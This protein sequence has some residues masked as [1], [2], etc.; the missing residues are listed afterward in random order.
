MKT[1]NTIIQIM[2]GCFM[3]AIVLGLA[4]IMAFWVDD[5]ETYHLDAY[6]VVVWVLTLGTGS[7]VFVKLLMKIKGGD[8]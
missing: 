3:G 2:L 5:P 7:Y 4:F 1:L 6:A 8:D